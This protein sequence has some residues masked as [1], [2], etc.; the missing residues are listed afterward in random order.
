MHKNCILY[1][2]RNKVWPFHNFLSFRKKKFIFI[3]KPSIL[4]NMDLKKRFDFGLF[5]TAFFHCNWDSNGCGRAG[6]GIEGGTKL[7]FS[8]CYNFFLHDDSIKLFAPN[9]KL[10]SSANYC[11]TII[12]SLLKQIYRRELFCIFSEPNTWG[13]KVVV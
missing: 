2:H 11:L 7:F 6:W 1:L 10:S 4:E 9:K 5:G 8:F 3:F 12:S 13:A